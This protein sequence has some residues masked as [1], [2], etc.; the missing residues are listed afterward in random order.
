MF[1]V[2]FIKQHVSKSRRSKTPL[3]NIQSTNAG[4]VPNDFP[5]DL[6]VETLKDKPIQDRRDAGL[7]DQERLQ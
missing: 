3:K 6:N 1:P 4:S 2:A 7:L 5:A